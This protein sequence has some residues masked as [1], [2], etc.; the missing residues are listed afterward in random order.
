MLS[1]MLEGFACI[2]GRTKPV[3]FVWLVINAYKSHPHIN[4]DMTKLIYQQ[5]SNVKCAAQ[6]TCE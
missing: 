1:A 5:R 4:I 2:V 6:V 3:M